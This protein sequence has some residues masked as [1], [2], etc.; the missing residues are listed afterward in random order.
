MRFKIQLFQQVIATRVHQKSV[1]SQSNFWPKSALLI[2]PNADGRVLIFF[3]ILIFHLEFGLMM[4][5]I[6]S[7]KEQG[8]QM[9]NKLLL[10]SVV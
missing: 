5:F 8:N 3:E 4:N 7:R 2:G 1:S 10:N 6:A 9:K